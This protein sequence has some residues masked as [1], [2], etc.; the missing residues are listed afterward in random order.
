MPPNNTPK[1]K[2]SINAPI[3]SK[4]MHMIEK[5]FELKNLAIVLLRDEAAFNYKYA[6][7]A[8]IQDKIQPAMKDLRLLVVHSTENNAVYT[9]IYN[10]DNPEQWCESFIDIGKIRTTR[11]WESKDRQMNI[12]TNKEE[13][14]NDAQAVGS[15]ITYYRRYNLLQLLDLKT[16]DDDGASASPRAKNN[17]S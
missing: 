17:S 12:I 6:D 14:D 3:E 15:I 8:Q 1:N 11:E 16:E 13:V 4:G 5:M 10:V 9:R 2:L 7:L